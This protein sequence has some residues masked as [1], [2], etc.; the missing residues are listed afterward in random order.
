[1]KQDYNFN[2]EMDKFNDK[3]KKTSKSVKKAKKEEKVWSLLSEKRKVA[4][5]E[6]SRTKD[7]H[8]YKTS[9][10]VHYR[11][12]NSKV[13]EDEKIVDSFRRLSLVK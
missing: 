1:M 7:E 9:A 2:R 6:N 13:H 4:W 11:W 5:I 8:L 12:M 10:A 3:F